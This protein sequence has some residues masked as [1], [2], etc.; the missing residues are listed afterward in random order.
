MTSIWRKRLKEDYDK[1]EISQCRL[2]VSLA[3]KYALDP[4]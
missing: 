3:E 2:L 1:S 4:W